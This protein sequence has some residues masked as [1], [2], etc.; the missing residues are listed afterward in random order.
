MV[1]KHSRNVRLSWEEWLKEKEGKDAEKGT[2]SQESE[3]SFVM[4]DSWTFP[5][6]LGGIA[7]EE[8]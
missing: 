8:E 7:E 4:K 5:A 1:K 3:M 6:E 2:V